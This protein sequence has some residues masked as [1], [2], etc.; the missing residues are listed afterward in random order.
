MPSPRGP[1]SPRCPAV[2]GLI[3]G[4]RL[5]LATALH[6]VRYPGCDTGMLRA[7]SPLPSSSARPTSWPLI[8]LCLFWGSFC[9]TFLIKHLLSVIC[10]GLGCCMDTSCQALSFWEHLLYVRLWARTVCQDL[11]FCVSICCMP[12]SEMLVG[13]A[14]C[15]DLGCCVSTYCVLGPRLLCGHVPCEHLLWARP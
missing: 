10:W 12:G 14:V 6:G 8:Q 11:D 9:V 7:C 4:S 15:L 13:T 3:L 5:G 2:R 1:A